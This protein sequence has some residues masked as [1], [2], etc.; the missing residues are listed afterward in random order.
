IISLRD[1]YQMITPVFNVAQDQTSVTINIRAPFIKTSNC[2]AMVLTLPFT[3]NPIIYGRLH[4]PGNLVEDERVK[5][6]YDIASGE[7]LMQI[8][9]ETPGEDFPDLDLLTKLLAPRKI[10]VPEKPSI[11]VV[12]EIDDSDDLNDDFMKRLVENFENNSDQNKKF[13]KP[14]IQVIEKSDDP[15]TEKIRKLIE[16]AESFDWELPQQIPDEKYILPMTASYGFNRLYS[17]YFTHVQETCNEII[18]ITGVEFSTF[19]SR[20]QD[21]INAENVKFD[22]DHYIADFMGAQ[23]IKHLIKYKTNWAK[24]LKR[25]QQINKNNASAEDDKSSCDTPIFIT[26]PKPASF[27]TN[28]ENNKDS[29]KFTEKETL[30]MMNLPNKT[31]KYYYLIQNTDA[32]YFGLVDLLYAYSYNNRVYEGEITVE[33]AW[34]IG[35]L[36]P[37]ISCL[38]E[39]NSL[40]ETIIAL[41]RRSLAYPWHRN[42][43]LSEKCLDDVYVLL[44]LGR[45]TILKVLLEIKDIFDHHDVYYIYSKIWLDDYCIWCQTKAN[46]K[47]IRLLAHNVHHFKVPKSKIG[48]H[49]EEYEQLAL[50]DQY[51]NQ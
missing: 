15:E 5:A 18:D 11:E 14:L 42:F 27:T 46:D 13:D 36:S 22:P 2:I 24:L 38:E 10:K 45:R 48:W 28:D 50:D 49:L 23:E 51:E 44:K 34:T 37:I 4:F 41:F 8:P 20:R 31:C 47:V 40:E 16:E 9:K 21:R 7:I 33:S 19:E 32:I 1:L 30:M 12:G 6:S 29:V 39:F 17:G 35:K 3:Q 26:Q 25:I 43:E